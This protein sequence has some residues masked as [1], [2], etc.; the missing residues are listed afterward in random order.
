MKTIILFIICSFTL[1]ET[2][3]QVILDS[4]IYQP[5]K[6]SN[7]NLDTNLTRKITFFVY[8]QEVDLHDNF[9]I[10]VI[11]KTDTLILTSTK[12]N[13]IRL[14]YKL[15]KN[16][17]YKVTFCP[18]NSYLSFEKVQGFI[19]NY[20]CSWE[21]RIERYPS[22][23]YPGNGCGGNGSE[24]NVWRFNPIDA[25]GMEIVSKRD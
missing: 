3:A 10:N 20:F 14:P 8:G 17:I 19:F 7:S 6:E 16:E 25:D 11:S 9:K 2:N 21:F 23:D 1:I 13:T 18:K 5:N 24:I 4:V 15:P 22:N 12:D